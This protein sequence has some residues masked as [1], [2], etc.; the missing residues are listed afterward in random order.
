MKFYF[1]MILGLIMFSVGIAHWHNNFFNYFVNFL[2]ILALLSFKLFISGVIEFTIVIIMVYQ[3]A[4]I[5]LFLVNSLHLVN[6]SW[7][8]LFVFLFFSQNDEVWV[9]RPIIPGEI[10]YGRPNGRGPRRKIVTVVINYFPIS[11]FGKKFYLFSSW[12][13]IPLD[14]WKSIKSEFPIIQSKN[15]TVTAL[16]F[17]DYRIIVRILRARSVSSIYFN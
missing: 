14:R 5:I 4:I 7:E 8:S 15:Y 2:S 6:L 16:N 1:G 17:R 11:F 9:D 10:T 13:W 12:F 3:S